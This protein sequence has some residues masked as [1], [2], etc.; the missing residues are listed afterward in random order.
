MHLKEYIQYTDKSDDISDDYYWSLTFSVNR[1]KLAENE[2]FPESGLLEN[3]DSNDA[4]V[5]CGCG[6]EYGSW[7]DIAVAPSLPFI[8]YKNPGDMEGVKLPTWL[9]ICF[10]ET[11]C[12][13]NY[14]G[15]Q[16]PP[17]T[18]HNL[19]YRVVGD[20]ILALKNKQ[21]PP[22]SMN[23]LQVYRE[24]HGI[25]PNDEV[26]LT[27]LFGFSTTVAS[28]SILVSLF[29]IH[30]T[31]N[32]GN[33]ITFVVLISMTTIGLEIAVMNKEG[34]L[35]DPIWK[36]SLF[37]ITLLGSGFAY[38][39]V[40]GN[41]M[42]AI[43]KAL[44]KKFSRIFK[45]DGD[46]ERLFMK[47]LWALWK[48]V[49][50]IVGIFW[51]IFSLIVILWIK[52][53]CK[54][55]ALKS[56]K[57]SEEKYGILFHKLKIRRSNK[58]WNMITIFDAIVF[59]GGEGV[60]LLRLLLLKKAKSPLLMTVLLVFILYEFLSCIYPLVKQTYIFKSVNIMLESLHP[61]YYN[62]AVI[63][64]ERGLKLAESLKRSKKRGGGDESLE[65]A[66]RR[67]Q[68]ANDTNS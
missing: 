39:L 57:L 66:A 62:V 28:V 33:R 65:L 4:F 23:F 45:D 19:F 16:V 6:V 38:F 2:E 48:A 22:S 63:R 34:F 68:S 46:S 49:W 51:A 50:F 10:S 55:F 61:R 25:P 35:D 7:G 42:L 40:L 52:G 64:R 54:I 29:F 60:L 12:T 1:A 53:R 17:E 3:A 8:Y 14:I 11:S 21:C 26:L 5:G 43:F 24:E 67:E 56:F 37:M 32:F 18:K 44:A 9:C 47:V 31:E 30:L 36:F 58:L 27:F 13:E 41:H 20:P 15:T 59:R